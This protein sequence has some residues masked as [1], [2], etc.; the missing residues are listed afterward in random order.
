M[1]STN[2]NAAVTAEQTEEIE[3]IVETEETEETEVIEEAEEP[4]ASNRNSNGLR[5]NDFVVKGSTGRPRGKLGISWNVVKEFICKD[6]TSDICMQNTK[7]KAQIH[8]RESK[9]TYMS[10]GG[11]NQYPHYA[12]SLH[13]DCPKRRKVVYEMSKCVV[14]ETQDEHVQYIPEFQDQHSCRSWSQECQHGFCGHAW[15]ST[16]CPSSQNFF[17]FHG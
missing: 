12:C 6:V 4:E 17:V 8:A 5:R 13:L 15:I 14:L 16:H 10:L 9:G 7:R 11:S 3:E 2:N 1:A